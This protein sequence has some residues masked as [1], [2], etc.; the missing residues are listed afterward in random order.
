MSHGRKP[1]GLGAGLLGAGALLLA[2]SAS[3]SQAADKA[4]PSRAAAS[5][6]AP[7]SAPAP[8][9]APGPLDGR[10]EG[11]VPPPSQGKAYVQFGVAFTVEGVVS[12]G[13][14]CANALDPCILGSGGGISVHA[15]WR[16]TETFYLGG[17]Y[18]FSKQDPAQLYRLGI[19]QQVRAE[20]RRYFPTG[21]SLAP[22]IQLGLGLC[23]YGDEWSIDTWGPTAAI[24][25]GIEIEL[26][27]RALVG[28]S[29]AYRPI[30]LR[31]FVDS[32]TL[33]HD[34]GVAH[35]IGFELALEAEDAL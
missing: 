12:A 32:S 3:Q 25:G 6:S 16:P 4:P 21:H 24:G 18:E 11:P 19:L 28:L 33:H 23:G 15:G 29:L 5:G 8:T 17:A 1:L 31:Q 10:P 35:L 9:A 34:A 14:V 27:E 13:P 2:A 30:Y 20:V 7:T 22:Y 26:S